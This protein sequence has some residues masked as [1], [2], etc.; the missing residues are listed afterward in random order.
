MPQKSGQATAGS[1]K[2]LAR[3][4]QKQRRLEMLQ[5][6]IG[7]SDL[8]HQ[9][10]DQSEESIVFE[11]CRVRGIDGL[12]GLES[13]GPE[14][15]GGSQDG[16]SPPTYGSSPN[17]PK[18][19]K[20]PLSPTLRPQKHSLDDFQRTRMT[21]RG[22]LESRR[23]WLT[24]E[25][26]LAEAQVLTD[27]IVNRV[28]DDVA[29][30]EPK[31]LSH[32]APSREH[33]LDASK[34]H[35]D[36]RGDLN[37]RK[38]VDST[39][40]AINEKQMVVAA[41]PSAGRGVYDPIKKFALQEAQ[42]RR[43]LESIWFFAKALCHARQADL[44]LGRLQAAT[45]AYQE[46]R[47][48]VM[49]P[50]MLYSRKLT[51]RGGLLG[52]KSTQV[53]AEL[54]GFQMAAYVA[55]VEALTG[56]NG[57]IAQQDQNGTI[58]EGKTESTPDKKLYH[59]VTEVIKPFTSTVEEHNRPV[60][61]RWSSIF[62]TIPV[63]R[64]P[65][66]IP[67]FLLPVTTLD[68]SNNRLGDTGLTVLATALAHLPFLVH[69]DLSGNMATSLGLAPV[70]RALRHLPALETL[71]VSS[72]TA[73][74]GGAML[75]G[76]GITA[77][78][79]LALLLKNARSLR[80]LDLKNV[81]L[82]LTGPAVTCFAEG[83]AHARTL[84]E[85][86][87]SNN[88]LSAECIRTIC[89]A[90]V[91]QQRR[92]EAE[93]KD[94][95]EG[96]TAVGSKLDVP[97]RKDDL[98]TCIG[99]LAAVSG[100]P[101]LKKLAR[102]AGSRLAR[103]ST[104]VIQA[105]KQTDQELRG[106]DATNEFPASERLDDSTD[107]KN[108]SERA[109]KPPAAES[110]PD[111]SKH[112]RKPKFRPTCLKVLNL[113]GNGF[114]SPGALFLS[115]LLRGGYPLQ[116]LRV[117]R[118]D[119]GFAGFCLLLDAISQPVNRHT[120]PHPIAM[121]S[122][123]NE[124]QSKP[125]GMS[126]SPGGF[127]G[128]QFGQP[129]PPN[130][131]HYAYLATQLNRTEG[132]TLL[133][134]LPFAAADDYHRLVYLQR[135]DFGENPLNTKPSLSY[136]HECRPKH[137]IG[138]PPPPS[139]SIT[140][141]SQAPSS[142]TKSD[143]SKAANH[144]TH[145]DNLTELMALVKDALISIDALNSY[146]PS[147][148]KY[149]PS[150]KV[151]QLDGCGAHDEFLV[152]LCE[153]L[154]LEQSD[155]SSGREFDSMQG[156]GYQS[157]SY[158]A[159]FR[160]TG[161]KV[162]GKTA[163]SEKRTAGES[164]QDNDASRESQS[165]ARK[166]M[167]LSN[168][169]LRLTDAALA[170]STTLSEA[171][172]SGYIGSD[173]GRTSLTHLMLAKNNFKLRG[174]EA[175]ARYLSHARDLV[176][177]NV[178]QNPFG[179]LG[180][181]LILLQ[182][183]CGE[184]DCCPNLRSLRL[185]NVGLDQAEF[186]AHNLLSAVTIDK[187]VL[188]PESKPIERRAAGSIALNTNVTST[189]VPASV[190]I[191]NAR[192]QHTDQI[193]LKRGANRAPDHSSLSDYSVSVNSVDSTAGKSTIQEQLGYSGPKVKAA[194][195]QILTRYMEMGAKAT[196]RGRAGA[197]PESPAWLTPWRS[198]LEDTLSRGTL[199]GDAILMALVE[200]RPNIRKLGISGNR[201]SFTTQ[202]VTINMVKFARRQYLASV[203]KQLIEKVRALRPMREH[204][205]LVARALVSSMRRLAE[206]QMVQRAAQESL[207]QLMALAPPREQ[208]RKMALHALRNIA[209]TRATELSLANQQ[210]RA[211]EVS[212]RR[213]V[214]A[215][216]EEI[217]QVERERDRLANECR[218]AENELRV[219]QLSLPTIELK[220]S[221]K[222]EMLEMHKLKVEAAVREL[223]KF[224]RALLKF[225][226]MLESE[227]AAR[228]QGKST[229]G[230]AAAA[231]GDAGAA[232]GTGGSKAKDDDDDEIG[233]EDLELDDAGDD[234]VKPLNAGGPGQSRG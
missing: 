61:S 205:A 195:I 215:L 163:H 116:S 35:F 65:K 105:L 229:R 100:L 181:A 158:D 167:L 114:R 171:G 118:C 24:L 55:S 11:M 219:Q 210:E 99:D 72:D 107:P 57:L 172:F 83:L 185:V 191:S 10:D 228:R 13:L 125:F 127:G 178:S 211:Q 7:F 14:G 218:R 230:I 200:S 140:T 193:S 37:R 213:K 166:S 156:Y 59:L 52:P 97:V 66:A 85:L 160:S 133:Q 120:A 209:R 111:S 49:L 197:A 159:G 174:A 198:R 67:D 137:G 207:M 8:Q 161:G 18:S 41:K 25:L 175:L 121:P 204:L 40:R 98:P 50:R 73:S 6:A 208:R 93:S 112:T 43:W 149:A 78:T 75:I 45:A 28:F 136:Q 3:K 139:A 188:Q 110:G 138:V 202:S 148:F 91:Y 180:T 102:A 82:G 216:E 96:N 31:S 86:D 79:E 194:V 201:L 44:G 62:D 84:Q 115:I 53:I 46:H 187:S 42:H 223:P 89:G 26:A 88:D 87:L 32:P 157:F 184:S 168:N 231:D 38:R 169:N 39:N 68:L 122:S 101:V 81:G 234:D 135:L 203:P 232:A 124:Y 196:S 104:D 190:Q 48:A 90:L 143:A 155:A 217:R 33:G 30:T 27:R 51:C 206:L 173:N 5:R 170:G 1:V 20:S 154:Q 153:V 182:L 146:V 179:S 63:T 132:G 69:L 199:S 144:P 233:G 222:A 58:E 17:Q 109:A 29:A 165:I 47:Y 130:E 147:S 2:G 94:D 71:D 117:R 141:P 119:I 131:N 151:L 129:A 142:P 164:T 92:I 36:Q 123:L 126:A 226:K 22:L 23:S 214:A 108:R 192:A 12:Q 106:S 16:L 77:A 113:S 221:E 9:T 19:P 189:T 162:S 76:P 70:F 64:V 152:A 54:L 128:V 177:L 74:G 220:I 21:R 56:A 212:F 60:A 183:L 4:G 225:I 15:E 224:R 80:R 176:S 34:L 150:L 103:A 227:E 95:A 134:D 186:P 145:I